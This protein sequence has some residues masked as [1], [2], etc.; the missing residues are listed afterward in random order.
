MISKKEIIEKI[1][2]LLEKNNYL[3]NSEVKPFIDD[4]FGP[5]SQAL[6]ENYIYARND[7]L[8][9]CQDTGMIEFFVFLGNKVELE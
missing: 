8:P 4:Y 7:K 6:K 5:F 9:L 2:T 1:S 3:I